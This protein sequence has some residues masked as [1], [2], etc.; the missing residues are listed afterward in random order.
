MIDDVPDQEGAHVMYVNQAVNGQRSVGEL[1]LTVIVPVRNAEHMIDDC[2]TAIRAANPREIIV[3]DGLSTDRT[4][5]IARRYDVTI[6]SDEGRGVA[7]ARSIGARA[8]RSRWV[9]LMDVDIVLPDGA[10][11]ALFDEFRGGSYTALQAGLRSV[12]GDGY[13]GRALV[14]HHR[15]GRSKNWPGVMATIFERDALL[16][17]GFD[18]RFLSGEDIELRW[19]LK[20]S[21]ARVGVSRDTVVEHRFDDT[22]DFARGQWLADGRGLGR[23]VQ[24]YRWRAGMLL[25]LP[26]AASVRGTLLSI[27][28]RQ[29]GWIPYYACYGAY[30]YVG[31]LATFGRSL[32][33]PG[34]AH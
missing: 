25:L 30:N 2:L 20:Q 1:D 16:S 14:N 34:S 32:R 29:P 33:M 19:R 22:F 6:V 13:W 4:I 21:G 23:M 3:V 31:M 28:H 27:I 24:K 26:L 11:T 10:L 7:A 9:A 17:Y 5:E 18:Q 12:S 15:R 8:A